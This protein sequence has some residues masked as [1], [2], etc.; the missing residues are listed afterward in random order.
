MPKCDNE[1]VI[2]CKECLSSVLAHFSLLFWSV[3]LK[4]PSIQDSSYS[5]TFLELHLNS[6]LFS[7]IDCFDLWVPQVLT[8]NQ[9]LGQSTEQNYVSIMHL[10]AELTRHLNRSFTETQAWWQR[11]SW[12]PLVTSSHDLMEREDL[13]TDSYTSRLVSTVWI[14]LETW[15]PLA[16]SDLHRCYGDGEQGA[17]FKVTFSPV[18]S[19]ILLF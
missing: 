5:S 15:C 4:T 9:V 1:S 17:V 14:H 6:P 10:E 8:V 12:E 2:L 7:E 18:A 3:I 13:E 16:F 19:T 11:E